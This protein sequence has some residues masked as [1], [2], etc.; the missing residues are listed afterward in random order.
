MKNKI[1]RIITAITMLCIGITFS[2]VNTYATESGGGGTVTITPGSVYNNPVS[3]LKEYCPNAEE[4]TTNPSGTQV[5]ITGITI[6]CDEPYD[7]VVLPGSFIIDSKTY[8][9]VYD[10]DVI[11][12]I[13]DVE[14]GVVL[15]SGATLAGL[16][17]NMDIPYIR[18]NSGSKLTVYDHAFKGWSKLTHVEGFTEAIEPQSDGTV[19]LTNTFSGCSSLESIT[20]DMKDVTCVFASTFANCNKLQT[21]N[22]K[23]ASIKNISNLVVRGDSTY[24]TSTGVNLYPMNITFDKVSFPAGDTDYLT[25]AFDTVTGVVT[26]KDC[27]SPSDNLINFN[28]AFSG[29]KGIKIKNQLIGNYN[30]N[31]SESN[32]SYNG[33]N[34]KVV[35]AGAYSAKNM[36]Y[37]SAY[38]I[39][40]LDNVIVAGTKSTEG[41]FSKAKVVD[42][43][44]IGTWKIGTANLSEMFNE[45]T[46]L[47]DPDGE[48]QI[49]RLTDEI[50]VEIKTVD[51]SKAFSADKMMCFSN[52]G[53]V[54]DYSGMNLSGIE[55]FA[56]VPG[57]N[58]FYSAHVAPEQY[59]IAA[60]S[61][62]YQT[63]EDK[64]ECGGYR[65]TKTNLDNSAIAG[66]EVEPDSFIIA[67]C[68]NLKIIRPS[69]GDSF[70][71]NVIG[72]HQLKEYLNENSRYYSDVQLIT[73]ASLNSVIN[74][75]NVITVYDAFNGFTEHLDAGVGYRFSDV[76]SHITGTTD[77]GSVA[78][79]DYDPE[80]RINKIQSPDEFTVANNVKSK[81]KSLFY[82]VGITVKNP[83]EQNVKTINESV[84]ITVP[85]PED[86]T[87]GELFVVHWNNGLDNAPEILN[88]TVDKPT[89]TVRFA[90]R[91]FSKVALLYNTSET[92]RYDITLKWVDDGNYLNRSAVKFHWVATY[93]NGVTD[94]GDVISRLSTE[95]QQI[96]SVDV[97]KEVVGGELED[98]KIT[99]T[100][101]D[102]I[103]HT[104]VWDEETS[105]L[106]LTYN[107]L[108]VSE[109]RTVQVDFS[110]V[111]LVDFRD[112]V[113]EHRSI[114]FNVKAEYEDGSVQ[115]QG[116]TK[117]LATNTV[118]YGVVFTVNTVNETGSEMTECTYSLNV[119]PEDYYTEIDYDKGIYKITK[120]QDVYEDWH[121]IHVTVYP[122]DFNINDVEGV[123]TLTFTTTVKFGEDKEWTAPTSLTLRPAGYSA[124]TT[125]LSVPGSCNDQPAT[126]TTVAPDAYTD[127]K[128]TAVSEKDGRF[129]FDFEPDKPE[130]PKPETYSKQVKIT[131]IGDKATT[132]PSTVTVTLSGDDGTTVQRDINIIK[133]VT[134]TTQ[135]VEV[136]TNATYTVTAAAGLGTDYT[137]TYSGLSV[138]ATYVGTSEEPGGKT[139]DQYFR[140]TISDNNN[141]DGSRPES[142]ELVVT[143]GKGSTQTLNASLG[144]NANGA[145]VK[146]ET[147]TPDSWSIQEI[148]GFPDRYKIVISSNN[149]NVTYTPE[150]MTKT[151][152]VK[153]DGDE[154]NRDDTR[155]TSVSVQIKN[156]DSI[157]TSVTTSEHTNW[158]ANA[159]VNK[160]IKGVEANYTIDASDVQNY[161]KS[162]D[163]DTITFKFTGTLSTK[164]AEDANTTIDGVK[165]TAL[166]ATGQEG[167]DYSLESFDWIDYANR[168]PDLKRAYGYN[169]QQL[170]AHYIR[171][172]IAE[173][174]R[175]T[176]TGKYSTI[177]E[178]ILAAY[179]P[180]D[181]KYAL[182]Q[183]STDSTNTIV[184]SSE[185][186]ITTDSTVSGNS[187]TAEPIDGDDGESI[188]G[189]IEYEDGT[190]VEKIT[191]EDGTVTEITKD[192]EGN[193]VS[194]KQYKTGDMRSVSG[195]LSIV[196]GIMLLLSGAVLCFY[197]FVSKR[198]R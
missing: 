137:L 40:T 140:V 70:E 62:Y 57:H 119:I 196:F 19:R 7:A 82:D 152:S 39:V 48:D 130:E 158:S 126:S 61:I 92:E 34:I 55:L 192:A 21:I 127:F 183:T 165:V 30:K 95:E 180:D 4:F 153:F 122:K 36:F 129:I 33:S 116:Y 173:G 71:Y 154:D 77:S 156:G 170:Y 27:T 25:G 31:C 18:F 138:I 166:N 193:I 68:V 194:T 42:I 115:E 131:F 175:A 172:G 1:L 147:T 32:G 108:T 20:L 159:E 109:N 164:K 155:P 64:E 163:G 150:K 123:I 63:D 145:T 44:G 59:S 29:S 46:I 181:Y 15:Q 49:D 111:D 160:Y 52:A 73:P 66:S 86:Y 41:M 67:E 189:I 197:T 3:K 91:S 76:I 118:V 5:M 85:I 78:L 80:I 185:E 43:N 58:P 72:G 110:D 8:S 182:I 88:S 162:V 143:D 96:L 174:R 101:I 11:Q 121:D 176:F 104:E 98:V 100:V 23:N 28:N 93:S 188:E 117:V 125:T 22:I 179:F 136:P 178:D 190:T 51:F 133:S 99:Y 146:I 106:T 2:T 148:K 198:P 37:D 17:D 38:G 142:I 9:A 191:S 24:S 90:M 69:I 75:G 54:P 53:Y 177:N 13:S 113:S 6:A 171:Y 10:A 187:I 135:V 168:Y 124:Y 83:D 114:T 50:N 79:V 120:E 134:E 139:Y 132:R 105:T 151:V 45:C 169:K 195:R 97:R 84:T 144:N 94:S 157:V 107:N 60:Q 16:R 26:F 184:E 12:A 128:F 47:Y 81:A 167:P 103:K 35:G 65:L 56:P 102:Q 149:A 161:S 186:S 89:S 112:F 87:S 141:E 14:K 74:G